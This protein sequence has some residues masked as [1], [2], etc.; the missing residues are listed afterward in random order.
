[1][2][3][4]ELLAQA[5]DIIDQRGEGYGGI[6]NNFQLAADLATL[7]I[8]R[9]FHPYEIAIIMACVKNARAFNTP[10]HLD[11][12]IDAVNYELFAATFAADY[13]TSH[14]SRSEAAYKRR[15]NMKVAR[16]SKNLKAASS[17]ELA[18]ILDEPS[19]SAVIGESA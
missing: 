3:P 12:H 1:M 9:E 18:V 13:A 15:D 4:Q 6:E 2:N 10:N 14:G 16:I 7:R 8:G 5:A 17:P 11:S 19:N